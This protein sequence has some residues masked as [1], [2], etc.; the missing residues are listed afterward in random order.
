MKEKELRRVR[1]LAGKKKTPKE[2]Q[3][4]IA[5]MRAR[6]VGAPPAPHITQI[7]RAMSGATYR[8]SQK[9][10][11]YFQVPPPNARCLMTR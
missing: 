2:V 11:T 1:Q 6:R 7:R 5:K 8:R 10:D 9:E 4:A 3:H